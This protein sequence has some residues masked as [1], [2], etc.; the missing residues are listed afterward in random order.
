MCGIAVALDGRR[1]VRHTRRKRYDYG[2]AVCGGTNAT[3]T[4]DNVRAWLTS[5]AARAAA[6]TARLPELRAAAEREH[7][8]H[9]ARIDAREREAA[10]LRAWTTKQLAKLGGGQ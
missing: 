7:A 10:A 4:D 5:E 6:E 8:A 1:I 2:A 3:V 9:L